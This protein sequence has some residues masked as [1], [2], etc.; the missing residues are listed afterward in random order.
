[1]VI[2]FFF[3][4]L[5]CLGFAAPQDQPIR[6]VASVDRPRVAPGELFSLTIEV[7]SE[8]SVR[9]PDLDLGLPDGVE[10][11]RQ[12]SSS[13]TSIQVT[14]GSM[15][16]THTVTF[17]NTLRI[18]AP[19][20]YVLGPARF[21]H[22]GRTYAS[23]ALRIEVVKGL[24]RPRTS[25][26][27]NAG[28]QPDARQLQEI[29]KNLFIRATAD[30]ESVYV[31]EQVVVSYDLYS[32]FQL[33][34]VRYGQLPSFTG[35][36]AETVFDAS[37]LDQRREVV[38]GQV[39]NRSTLKKVALFPTSAGVHELEQLEV[40]C[41]I[42]IRTRRRNMF[43]M[44]DFLGFDPFRTQQVVVR[45]ADVSIEVKPLPKRAPANFT[46][47]VGEY[48]IDVDVSPLEVKRG[49]PV[50]MKV[51]V[52][53][54]GNLHAV[55][56]PDLGLGDGFRTYDPKTTLDA[57]FDGR[58]VVGEKTFEFVVIPQEEEGAIRLPDVTMAYFDPGSRTYRMARGQPVT[59]QVL[60]AP[61]QE[62]MSIVAPNEGVRLLGQ[63]IR[64]IK[65]DVAHLKH[66]DRPFYASPWFIGLQSLPIL[67]FMGAL[68]WK[69]H[70]ARLQGDV[71][72][73]RRRRSKTAATKRF[74]NADRFLEAGD[75][76]ACCFEIH[77]ALSAFLA[78]RFNLADRDLTPDR[79]R[80][81]LEGAG[82]EP[83]SCST[84]VKILEACDA[85]RFAPTLDLGTDVRTML[86]RSKAVVDS[87]GRMA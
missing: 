36:W 39:Y 6:V 22:D 56:V 72:Y 30:H 54:R 33:K 50:T 85:A 64:H 67:G 29:E 10:L 78:D 23:K 3:L 15:T 75:S 57:S 48:E 69:R 81:V 16:R 9:S 38:D 70:Q 17:T 41:D 83:E 80:A 1:V 68:G 55:G 66:H 59:L 2:A 4:V 7:V 24:A 63:D 49:D 62:L 71:A 25:S 40:Q 77:A 47:G 27:R 53:G 19:G 74:Q 28:A 45:A 13:S 60:P 34:N 52:V 65:G 43:D 31:G 58:S 42:P 20:T 76:K 8:A 11:M 61:K 46:G 26:N 14:G 18:G 84:V 73:A 35:F 37:R 79:A 21:N 12:S 87:L 44:D 32:R 82:V 51:R 5:A 86:E